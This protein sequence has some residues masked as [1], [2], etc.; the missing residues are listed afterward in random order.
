MNI[1]LIAILAGITLGGTQIATVNMEN[2]T[3]TEILEF[4][5][6]NQKVFLLENGNYEFR[7]YS[8][9]VHYFNGIEMVE[10]NDMECNECTEFYKK[11]END[12][13]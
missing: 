13:F 10:L 1:P 11:S 6:E 4:R 9:P 7:F 5:T 3:S 2:N 8:N 12:D